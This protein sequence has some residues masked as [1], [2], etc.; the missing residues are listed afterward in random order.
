MPNNPED[1]PTA[2][3]Y[4]PPLSAVRGAY[5]HATRGMLGLELANKVFDRFV[6]ELQRQAIQRES[7]QLGN[8]HEL[9]EERP[10]NSM[11]REE[12]RIAFGFLDVTGLP[13]DE[14]EERRILEYAK[15]LEHRSQQIDQRI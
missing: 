15:W 14:H 4:I 10:L 2:S 7:V 11:T 1:A 8:I 6:S 9:V 5:V 13:D 3:D 12:K